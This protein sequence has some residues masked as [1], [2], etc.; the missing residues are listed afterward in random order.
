MTEIPYP[1]SLAR[2]STPQVGDKSELMLAPPKK[3][4]RRQRTTMVGGLFSAFIHMLLLISL[5]LLFSTLHPE[6]DVLELTVAL[7][8]DASIVAVETIDFTIDRPSEDSGFQTGDAPE[9]AESRLEDPMLVLDLE[10]DPLNGIEVDVA[11]RIAD[12]IGTP[13]K[14]STANENGTI[15]K[16]SVQS[17]RGCFP[18]R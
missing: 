8:T 3:T 2:P 1:D 11:A 14:S 18:A 5:G 16:P 9:H 15:M 6:T 13:A 10:A 17:R 12:A 7:R 4:L